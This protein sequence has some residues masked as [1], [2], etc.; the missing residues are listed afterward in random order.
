MIALLISLGANFIPISAFPH[1]NHTKRK[2]YILKSVKEANMN[3]IRIWGGG[4][5]ETDEFYELADEYGKFL[6]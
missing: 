6:T 2:Q 4:L 3:T 1:Q 5:Y